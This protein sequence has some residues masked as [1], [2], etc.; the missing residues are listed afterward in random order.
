[1]KTSEKMIA[2]LLEHVE[3]NST[4]LEPSAGT[5][6]V[7][8]ELLKKT[9]K[10]TAFELNPTKFLNL[11]ISFGEH[12]D[13]YQMDFLNVEVE[14]GEKKY[15]HVVAV[16]PYK[17]NVDCQHIMKMYECAKEGGTVITFTLPTWITGMYTNQRKF[18]EWLADKDYT[19]KIFEEPESYLGCPKMLLIIRK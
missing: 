10:V 3:P 4:V 12:I 14:D 11:S 8:R 17:D 15:D 1:M 19:M 9:K 7:I 13:A 6:D 2:A 5:G 18:R 16:P